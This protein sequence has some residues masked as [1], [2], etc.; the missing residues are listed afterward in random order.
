MDFELSVR[1]PDGIGVGIC[2]LKFR[3]KV[4]ARG[5]NHDYD[6]VLNLCMSL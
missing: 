6:S 5:I 1:H 3:G 4:Q 2:G